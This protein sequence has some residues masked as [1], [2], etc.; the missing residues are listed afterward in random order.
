MILRSRIAADAEKL[1]RHGGHPERLY[2]TTDNAVCL[3][4]EM[5]SEGGLLAHR[6]MMSGLRQVV[7]GIDGLKIIWKS[8]RFGI[9]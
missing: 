8:P 9:A 4:Y 2:L 5:I 6:I 7:S 1:R 3:Q